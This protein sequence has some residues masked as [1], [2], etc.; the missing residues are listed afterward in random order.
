MCLLVKIWGL[1]SFA[2]LM[3]LCLFFFLLILVS[4]KSPAGKKKGSSFRISG[5]QPLA[6]ARIIRWKARPQDT[7]VTECGLRVCAYRCR[8][9][10]GMN[11]PDI[12]AAES[13][14]F[15]EGTLRRVCDEKVLTCHIGKPDRNFWQQ[16]SASMQFFKV[17]RAF[18]GHG[19]LSS[20][21]FQ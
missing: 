13:S 10:V 3:P 11:P 7:D 14:A 4:L 8:G 20:L 21:T 18:H 1:L 19:S 12:R 17:M 9:S 6:R 2:V 16:K 15:E 5:F